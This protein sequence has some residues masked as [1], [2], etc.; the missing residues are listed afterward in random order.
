ML[1]LLGNRKFSIGIDPHNNFVA[2]ALLC[3]MP[4]NQIFQHWVLQD[5]VSLSV[6]YTVKDN[7]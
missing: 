7:N 3:K 2:A 6:V 1:C 5:I 4:G